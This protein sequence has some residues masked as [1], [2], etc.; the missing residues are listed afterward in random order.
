MATIVAINIIKRCQA[1]S[2]KPDG[3][4]IYQKTTAKRTIIPRLI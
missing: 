4:G 1:C 3:T 2:V